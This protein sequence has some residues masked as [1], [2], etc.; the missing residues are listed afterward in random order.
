MGKEK[1]KDIKYVLIVVVKVTQ[2]INAGGL[3]KLVLQELVQIIRDKST[4]SQLSLGIILSQSCPQI[5]SEDFKIS[6]F[7]ISNNISINLTIHNHLPSSSSVVSSVFASGQGQGFSGHQLRINHCNSG[8]PED[9]IMEVNV[10]NPIY[11][12]GPSLPQEC[13]E[14]WAAL[15][16]TGAVASIA[17]QSLVPHIHIKEKSENLTSVN[18]GNIKVLARLLGIKHVTFITGKVIIHVNFL[19]VEDVKNPILGLDAIHHNHYHQSHYYAS[20]LVLPDHAQSHH[21]R[22]LDPHFTTLDKQLGSN[23]ITEIDDKITSDSRNIM[24]EEESQEDLSQQAQVPHCLKVPSTPS[25]AER[26]LHELTHLPF[27]SWCEMRQR[28]KGLQGQHKHQSQ[29]KSSVIQLDHSFY[30]V[31]GPVQNLKILSFIETSTSMCGAV[32]VPDLSANQVGVKA[33]KQFTVVNGLTDRVLQCDGHSGLMKFQ[34][35]VG[36]DLSLPTQIS[37]PYSH[38]SQGTV[39]RF[40][41]TLYGQARASKLGLVVRLGVHPDSTAARLM[42]R[43]V[44][45]AV[46]NINRHLIRQDGKASYEQVFNKAHSGP[47]VHF[48]EEGQILKTRAVTHLVKDQQFNPVEFNKIILPPHESEPHYQ[49]PSR[50]RQ[51]RKR[52]GDHHHCQHHQ[53]QFHHHNQQSFLSPQVF[54]YLRDFKLNLSNLNNQVLV[55]LRPLSKRLKFN[56]NNQFRSEEESEQSQNLR[57][58]QRLQQCFRTSRKII[59]LSIRIRSMQIIKKLSQK[60]SCFKVSLFRNGIKGKRC[61][62]RQVRNMVAS[63]LPPRNDRNS[64]AQVWI[65]RRLCI[66]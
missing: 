22:W 16:D 2:S 59:S 52:I 47:L 43:I 62:I 54:R 6:D 17:P 51:P 3:R 7:S 63:W 40:H 48:G 23:I 31:P 18:G 29:K 30:K 34:D 58:L 19:I 4:I 66:N 10:T 12:I 50:L 28:A 13:Q 8:I 9:Y 15:I 37:P 14:P 56:L 26:E 65:P 53:Q 39:E 21:L 60:K 33:L 45:H 36:K 24:L 61:P 49:E 55:N 1:V 44:A 11:D 27:R 35:Q 5:S 32:I 41:K 25:S 20:G 46:F 42:P 64:G 57:T 38:Q